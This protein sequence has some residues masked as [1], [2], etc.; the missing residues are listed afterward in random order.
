M[1]PK[2]MRKQELDRALEATDAC[3]ARQAITAVSESITGLTIW[4]HLGR[5]ALQMWQVSVIK[6]RTRRAAIYN[7]RALGPRLFPPPHIF[8]SVLGTLNGADGPS[9][10]TDDPR[11]Q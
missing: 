6:L 8:L 2:T 7:V 10:S 1:S 11:Y 4:G 5:D 3:L 9:G